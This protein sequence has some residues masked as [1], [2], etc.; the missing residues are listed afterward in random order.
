M[1]NRQA[2]M[3][4]LMVNVTLYSQFFFNVWLQQTLQDR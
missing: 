4:L 2:P 3:L 1:Q